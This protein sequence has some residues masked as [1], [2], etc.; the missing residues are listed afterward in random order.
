MLCLIYLVGFSPS[1]RLVIILRH[2]QC[3]SSPFLSAAKRNK[4]HL[5]TL[6]SP[7]ERFPLG[8][9]VERRPVVLFSVASLMTVNLVRVSSTECGSGASGSGVESCEQDR[10]RTFGGSWDEDA[11][12]D[13]CI[14]DFS[15]GSVPHST[16]G[17]PGTTSSRTLTSRTGVVTEIWEHW[18]CLWPQKRK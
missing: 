10:C 11:E 6:S 8:S 12:D 3:L 15:C 7:T 16:V 17:A 14:C 4:N 9:L 2:Q 5:N 18:M 1:L 13:R